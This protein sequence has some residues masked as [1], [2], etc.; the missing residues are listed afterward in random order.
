MNYRFQKIYYTILFTLFL[1]C[2]PDSVYEPIEYVFVPQDLQIQE[3]VGIKLSSN[4]ANKSVDMNVKLNTDG[5]Y[6]IKIKDNYGKV[7]AKEKVSGKIGDNIF[8]VYTSTLP[9][10]SYRIELY[11]EDSKI[12]VTQINITK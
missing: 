1:A 9:K 10:S 12:G 11:L 8:K 2:T 7:I 4:F 3:S 6:F 5:N